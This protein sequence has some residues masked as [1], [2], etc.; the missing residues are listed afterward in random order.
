[1]KAYMIPDGSRISKGSAVVNLLPLESE[2]VVSAIVPIKNFNE[3]YLTL[4]TK[5]GVIK[6]TTVDQFDTSRKSGLIAVNLKEDDQLISVKKTSGDD[7]MIVITSKGKSIRFHENDVRPMGRTATGVRA[8]KLMERDYVIDMD[9]VKPE[10]RLLVVSENGYGKR[11][12]LSEYRQQTRGGKGIMTYN[13]SDKTGDLIGAKVTEDN[14]DLMIINDNGVLIRIKID[15]ISVTGR[16]T[17]GVKLMRVDDDTKLV[18]IAKIQDS[19]EEAEELKA[20]DEEDVKIELE[21]EPTEE[22]ITE[23]IE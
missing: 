23:E 20:V 16:I 1:M 19:D 6:K 5:Q 10:G 2:E 3:G 21:A 9:I 18:S 22:K 8:I 11:T 4:C 13:R 12:L 15:D 14:E 17:S 7:E